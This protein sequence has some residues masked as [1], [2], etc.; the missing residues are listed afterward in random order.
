MPS[1][2]FRNYGIE[3]ITDATVSITDDAHVGSRVILSRAAGVTVTLPAAT[4]SGNRYEFIV[5]VT[6][7][8]NAHVINTA[9]TSDLYYGNALYG[10]DGGD[11]TV[12]FAAD[13]SDDDSISL[14]GTTTGGIKGARVVLDDIATN[15]WAVHIVSD[16]SGTE[17]TP[18]S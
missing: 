18:F 13:G 11:T 7:T 15:A 8:S 9:S 4:G 5:G 16:A 3:T 17:A 1:S 14:N 10:A 2:Y 12:M 6:P